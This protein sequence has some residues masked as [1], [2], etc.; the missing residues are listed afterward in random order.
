[1]TQTDQTNASPQKPARSRWWSILLIA[2]LALNCLLVGAIA[3][4]WY[5]HERIER[6]SGASYTQLLP[7]RFMGDLPPERRKELMAIL[8]SYRKEFRD[9]RVRLRNA[10]IG[11]ADALE[12]EPYDAEAASRA[13]DGFGAEASG[14]IGKGSDV[15]REV[16][17]KLTPEERKQLAL[18]V[19]ER[20]TGRKGGDDG[21]D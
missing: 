11:I 2:S 18:R 17:A 6:F 7:R 14:L 12:I 19:R 20:S 1:M 3:A 5:T 4:R 16:L 21:P 9:G 13:I 15:A 10:A 8:G